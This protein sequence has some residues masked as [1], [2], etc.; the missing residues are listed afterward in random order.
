MAY[1]CTDCS[2][3]GTTSGQVGECP[4]CGSFKISRIGGKNKKEP[5]SKIR[6]AVLVGLWLYLTGLIIWKVYF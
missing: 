4:A 5:H 2:Y 3:R 6:L 1:Y